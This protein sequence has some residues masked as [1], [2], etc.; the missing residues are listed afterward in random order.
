MARQIDS[1]NIRQIFSQQSYDLSLASSSGQSV[2]VDQDVYVAASSGNVTIV[3]DMVTSNCNL[4]V[5]WSFQ[6]P[7]PWIHWT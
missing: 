2:V 7:R 5:S 6:N 3:A 1:L 4:L